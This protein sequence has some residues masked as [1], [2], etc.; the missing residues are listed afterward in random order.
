[1]QMMLELP[2]SIMAGDDLHLRQAADNFK[3]ERASMA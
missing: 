1:M 3:D 2:N